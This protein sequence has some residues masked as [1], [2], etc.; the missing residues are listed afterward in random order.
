M[1]MHMNCPFKKNCYA[2]TAYVKDLYEI[3]SKRTLH[4]NI[5][6]GWEQNTT[7]ADSNIETEA[8]SFV[9]GSSM[10]FAGLDHLFQ[11]M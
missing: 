7:L 10:N 9:R 2:A 4:G 5:T 3:N 11:Q 8:G 6:T 1:C